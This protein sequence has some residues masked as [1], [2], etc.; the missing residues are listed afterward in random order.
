[1]CET[2][3]LGKN[4]KSGSQGKDVTT[5]TRINDCSLIQLFLISFA[6][7]LKQSCMCIVPLLFIDVNIIFKL[8]LDLLCKYNINSMSR[9]EGRV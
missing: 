5:I 3:T 7:T 6:F 1:M 8:F 2:T 4:V 9:R